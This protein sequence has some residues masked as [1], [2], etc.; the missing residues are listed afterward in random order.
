M[1]STKTANG[2]AFY[3]LRSFFYLPRNSRILTSTSGLWSVGSAM[4]NPY[5]SLYFAALGTS[6]LDI[7]MLVAFGTAVTFVALLVGGYVAD[8]WGRRR[9]IIIFSWV[10]V[11]SAAMYAAIDSWYLILIPLTFNSVSSMYTPAFNSLMFDEIEPG[12]RIR[13]F[14]VFSAINTVPSIFAPTLGGLLM[15]HF[16]ILYG[17]K[18]AYVSSALFGVLGV[19]IRTRA[20]HE[21][22][23]LTIKREKKS[24]LAYISESFVSGFKATRRSNSIVKRLLLYTTLA[25][26]GT[27]LTSPFASIY[28][29]DFLKFDPISYSLIVD[30]AGL[31]TVCLMLAVVFLIQRMGARN[32]VLVASIAAPVSNVMFSQA[33]TM[34]EL[35]EWGVTGAVGTAIQTTSLSTMQAEAI[36]LEH[37]GK[38]LAMFSILPALMSLPSQVAGGLLYQRIAPVTPFLMSIVPFT[39]GAI[40]LFSIRASRPTEE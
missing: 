18:L 10:S 32:G 37:R 24:F 16:G 30:F 25:G 29:V 33:K 28:V 38:I 23:V 5:Q 21:T 9:V 2:N 17:I 19:S 15:Q 39:A 31:T 34:D 14:S 27:G 22:Y 12:D 1:T 3:K 4:A 8:T 26:I 20:L 7:G 11:A 40:V 6:P 35:L 36:E 13:G